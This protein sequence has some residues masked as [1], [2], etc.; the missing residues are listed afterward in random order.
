MVQQ[1]KNRSVHILA[2]S[3]LFYLICPVMAWSAEISL[4]WDP[5]NST[6]VVGYKLHFGTSTGNYTT[7]IDVGDHTNWTVSELELNQQYFF[8]ATAYSADAL[9]SSYS[10]EVS[11]TVVDSDGDGLSDTEEIHTYGTDP[12]KADTDNDGLEDGSEVTFWDAS[13][14]SWDADIDGDGLMNLLDA[15]SDGDGFADGQEYKNNTDPGDPGST[16]ASDNTSPV[17]NAGNDQTVLEAS[18]VTLDGSNSFDPDGDNISYQWSQLT[19]PEVLLSSTSS[20]KPIF[21]AP[22]VSSDGASLSFSLTVTDEHGK[23]HSDTTIVNVTWV[24]QA[25]KADAGLDQDVS[26]E[27]TVV[28]D[29]MR[30]AD[31]DDGIAVFS[32]TQTSGPQVTISGADTATPSFQAPATD[33]EGISLTFELVVTDHLGLQDSDE[34]RVNVSAQY[35]APSAHAGQDQTVAEGTTVF[36]NGLQSTDPDDDLTTYQWSQISGPQVTISDPTSHSP[37]FVTPRVPEKGTELEFQLTVQD[38]QG[39]SNSDSVLVRV[40]DNGI[41]LGPRV[42]AEVL[43]MPAYDT[44]INC[45]VL[46]GHDTPLIAL[47]LISP[48]TVDNLSNQSPSPTH[49]LFYL[50]LKVQSPGDTAQVTIFFD[51]PM[52]KDYG[53]YKYDSQKGWYE[54]E[55]AQFSKN[56]K[57]VRLTLV[58]GGVGDQDGVKNGIIVDPSGPVTST[59]SDNPGSGGPSDGEDG[60]GDDAGGAAPDPDRRAAPFLNIERQAVFTPQGQHREETVSIVLELDAHEL[61]GKKADWWLV[62]DSPFGVFSYVLDRG[63]WAPGVQPVMQAEVMSIPKIEVF[64]SPLPP[65]RYTFFWALDD[66]ADGIPDATWLDF[67]QVVVPE[68]DS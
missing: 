29:G 40:N 35:S 36:L 67:T 54:F 25:P 32:W 61:A 39:L 2:A 41:D 26:P 46:A 9:E 1:I 21:K 17:A 28:L 68:N 10:N 20:M 27:A 45:G 55:N 23:T 24:N 48:E 59:G 47:D 38:E 33:T 6:E 37:Y 3:L 60:P 57:E 56:R 14:S 30:S 51:H 31:P 13:S 42:P 4:T 64:K 5:S 16:P 43:T 49:P 7:T 50:E 52:P 15:D 8:A 18:E 22:H 62:V 44:G 11:A 58:D 12:E 66:N 19:G 34:C 65:G 63:T 53:W